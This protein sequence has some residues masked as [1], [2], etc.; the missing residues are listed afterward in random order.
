MVILDDLMKY[1]VDVVILEAQG[2]GETT[3]R[4]AKDAQGK[5]YRVFNA[6][7]LLYTLHPIR[8]YIIFRMAS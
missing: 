8:M 2:D 6:T 1:I 4:Q 3:P 7:V 5:V